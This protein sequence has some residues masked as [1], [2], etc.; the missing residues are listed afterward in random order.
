MHAEETQISV[1]T[2]DFTVGY[3]FFNGQS[4]R[5][6]HIW[7]YTS[8]IMGCLANWYPRSNSELL[9]LLHGYTDYWSVY[10]LSDM[11]THYYSFFLPYGYT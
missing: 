6:I 9:V 7:G 8:K 1:Y 3:Q 5:T 2:Q 4:D 10:P 11:G